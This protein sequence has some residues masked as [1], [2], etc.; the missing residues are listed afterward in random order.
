MDTDTTRGCVFCR[1]VA[2]E[3]PA[4]VVLGFLLLTGASPEWLLTGE[5]LKYSQGGSCAPARDGDG[6]GSVVDDG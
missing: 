2:Q 1:I 6:A 4:E 5:G 3:L